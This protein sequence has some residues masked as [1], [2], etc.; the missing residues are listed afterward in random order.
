MSKKHTVLIFGGSFSPP[1]LAHE[2]ILG[3]CLGLP[4]FDEVWIM[5][6][7]ERADKSMTAGDKQRLEMAE[8]VK[9]HSFPDEPRLKVSD[10]ELNLPRPTKTYATAEALAAKHPDTEFWWALGTDAFESMPDTW[11]NGAELQKSMKLLVFNCDGEAKIDQPNVTLLR[12]P[13]S[14]AQ[15]SSTN[16]RND[17]AAGSD[18]NSSVSPAVLGY[19]NRNNLYK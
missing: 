12:L 16:V 1:T 10:F 9:A 7:G 8:L 6:C 14:L 3:L 13:A 15:V 17:V 5:P 4:Q 2:A 18:A 19:I 11:E